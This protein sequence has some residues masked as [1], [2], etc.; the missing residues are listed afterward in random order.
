MATEFTDNTDHGLLVALIGE[1][2]NALL[3]ALVQLKKQLGSPEA[4]KA[5]AAIDRVF[6]FTADIT[7]ELG[8]R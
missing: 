5:V 8:K 4:A 1:T 3:P 2:R 7:N 6:A